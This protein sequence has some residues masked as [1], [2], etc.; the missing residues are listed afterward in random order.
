MM[1]IEYGPG[2]LP[3]PLLEEKKPVPR[4][5]TP[6][7]RGDIHPP[8]GCC[9]VE[10]VEDES[11]KVVLI[12]AGRPQDNG[13][14][15]VV[16]CNGSDTYAWQGVAMPVRWSVGDVL[17]FHPEKGDLLALPKTGPAQRYMARM[18]DVVGFI[19]AESAAATAPQPIT[20]RRRPAPKKKAAKRATKKKATRKAGR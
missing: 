16:V 17:L 15:L 4:L 12:S 18:L 2:A 14:R 3:P 7:E 10:E 13:K 9:V 8:A 19:P 11:S 5:A 1:D 20:K 6:L